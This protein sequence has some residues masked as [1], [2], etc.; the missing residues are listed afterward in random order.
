[1]SQKVSCCFVSSAGIPRGKS[2]HAR[3][4]A[5]IVTLLTTLLAAPA[6]SQT[7]EELS[8]SKLRAA[9]EQLQNSAWRIDDPQFQW[10]GVLKFPYVHDEQARAKNRALSEATKI[11]G[12]PA[13]EFFQLLAV[14]VDKG[15]SAITMGFCRYKIQEDELVMQCALVTDQQKRLDFHFPLKHL[16]D[17]NLAF[18]AYFQTDGSVQLFADWR[19]NQKRTLRKLAE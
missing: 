6:F 16:T 17:K 14:N 8:Q 4:I 15:K 2:L 3:L 12:H 9:V 11:D 10:V 1:M 19:E 13:E 5:L 18:D 7:R